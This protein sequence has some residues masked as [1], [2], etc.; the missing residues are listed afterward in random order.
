MEKISLVTQIQSLIA[1]QDWFFA[2]ALTCTFTIIF[3]LKN[4]NNFSS[5]IE[6]WNKTSTR[7]EKYIQE[8]LK[9]KNIS[10][11][12]RKHL[13]QKLDH[14][15]LKKTTGIPAEHFMLV[16]ILDILEKSCGELTTPEINA[17]LPMLHVKESALTTKVEW[18]HFPL[19]I[20]ALLVATPLLFGS[21]LFIIL[22]LH[23]ANLGLLK[24][25]LSICLG[26]FLFWYSWLLTAPIRSLII[27]KR[28]API[29]KK[30]QAT[31]ESNI[32]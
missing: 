8:M 26:L 16:K 23:V 24:G 10:P 18:W 1:S 27:A 12:T 13:S 7:R 3:G 20:L 32:S 9:D 11:Q 19:C 17:A 6:L 21:S 25:L 4:L 30:L 22:P 31:P 29:I 28:I 5:A 15:V 2:F 14:I